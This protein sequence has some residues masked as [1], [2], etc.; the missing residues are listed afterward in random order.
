MLI[1]GSPAPDDS[2]PPARQ[3]GSVPNHCELSPQQTALP[4]SGAKDATSLWVSPSPSSGPSASQDQVYGPQCTVG[5]QQSSAPCSSSPAQAPHTPTHAG[6]S[7]AGSS[8]SSPTSSQRTGGT[9]CPRPQ[10]TCT[11]ARTNASDLGNYSCLATSHMDFSTKSVFSKF[12]PAQPGREG[13]GRC[14]GPGAGGLKAQGRW[15]TRVSV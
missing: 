4:E 6:L 11:Y 10:G 9:S 12:A 2:V 3:T 15:G 1:P 13:Q 8:M 7:Y 14:A 5:S